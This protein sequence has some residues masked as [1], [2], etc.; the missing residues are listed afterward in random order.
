MGGVDSWSKEGHAVFKRQQGQEP[1]KKRL[2]GKSVGTPTKKVLM[3][4]YNAARV[5]LL[6]A[7][8]RRETFGKDSWWAGDMKWWEKQFDKARA[9]CL[10]AGITGV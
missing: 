6:L 1:P 8:D 9:A 5:D 7:I 10:K 4:R 2:K 3:D